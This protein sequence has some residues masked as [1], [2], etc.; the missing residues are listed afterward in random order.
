MTVSIENF[1]K[2]IYNQSRLSVADTRISTLARLLNISNA[3][4]TDM[5]RK[6]ATKKLV[7]YTKYKPLT[8][9]STGNNLALN[10]IRKHRLWESFLYKTLNLSLHEI[11]KEAENLEHF[12]SD[13]LADKIE[14]YLDYPTTDPH[15]DPIPVLNEETVIDHSQIL[16]SD[17]NAGYEY[18]IS[19]LFSSEKDF[20]D[21][22][23]SNHIA[24]GSTIW[25]E[26]Q[27]NANKM[28]EI[29]IN[30]NKILLNKDFTNI[31]YVKQLN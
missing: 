6:L 25:V 13:F 15:G 16:L 24:I 26:K 21:F 22:C 20:F 23:S 4:A 18:E 29:I 27:F 9:T 28:T 1:V 19:R 30:K 31:I 17:A 3:A 2:T 5:A 10:V 11:H 12:T 7:N 8:L 14:K